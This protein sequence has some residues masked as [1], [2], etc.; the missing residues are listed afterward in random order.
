MVRKPTTYYIDATIRQ[1]FEDYNWKIGRRIRAEAL[2]RERDAYLAAR[3][4]VCMSRW[5]ADDVVSSYDVPPQRV[6][7]IYPG[8]N[9]DDAS[10]PPAPRWDGNLSPLRLG[11]IGVDW[12]RKGGPLLL[13]VATTLQR[14][15]HSVEVVI[16]GPDPSTI[17]SHPAVRAIGFVDK[18]QEL[19]RFVTLARSFH[20]GC[21][22]SRAEASGFS[23]L[24]SLRLGI[25]VIATAV[26]GL[27][28]LPEDACLLMPR[29]RTSESLAEALDAV[30]RTPE[31]YVTM[32]E[33]AERAGRY[34]S[35]D[36]TAR[37]FIGLLDS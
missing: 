7:V 10:I 1:F 13:D 27:A 22:L 37:E 30:I 15:G 19:P 4:V 14:M 26:G 5:C 23:T 31:R 2:A 21:L 8:A 32:R 29:E 3:F 17:P 24:E 12:E 33:A 20:F 34:Y 28:E 36:R 6:R 16:I 25:P 35:W 18:A 11:F 9:I